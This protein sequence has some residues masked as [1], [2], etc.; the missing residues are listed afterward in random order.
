MSSTAFGGALAYQAPATQP[1]AR[2][3]LDSVDLLRGLV[4]VLMALDHVRDFFTNLRFDA[5]DLTRT[6][7]PLFFTRWVT[8]FCAPTFVFLAGTGAF[9]ALRRGKSRGELAR[10]L[11]SRGLWLVL[12]E[13]TVIRLGWAF[14][15]DYAGLQWV[16]VIW[17]IGIS[18]V[19]LAGLIHLPLPGIA[20]F[21]VA[22][23]A[24]HNLA[25]GIDPA[26]LGRWGTLWTF[27]HVQ[28]AVMLP[29]GAPLFVAYPLVPWIGVM[30]VGYAFGSILGLPAEERRRTLLRLGGG[31]TA[32][33]VIIRATNVYGDPRPWSA[34]P[35]ALFTAMSFINTTKYPPSLLFLLM[36]L[37]PAIMALAWF[38]R[39]GGAGARFLTV[40][41]RVPL[42]YYVLHLF[43]IHALVMAFGIM[44]GFPPSALARNPFQLPDGWGYGLPV[45]Y[46]VWVA[47]VLALYPVCRWFAALKARRREAWLSYL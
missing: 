7:A 42:F 21:G 39:I 34:Q 29:W 41:G 5:A 1:A 37:G 46:A 26:G 43:L 38:E 44:A 9:L 18:M 27:L 8:H 33:F 11:V 22:L 13:L 32:A 15:L 35:S 25:D 2:V 14:N 3:R 24:L 16:Q 6:N 23:I 45:V 17:V 10:F 28:G 20:A 19:V 47:V 30:A 31:L 36:T 12:L 4:M 40:F